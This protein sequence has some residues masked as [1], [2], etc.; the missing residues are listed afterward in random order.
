MD[1]GE[2]VGDDVERAGETDARVWSGDM[3]R[4]EMEGG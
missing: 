3:G 1:F 4:K 2:S